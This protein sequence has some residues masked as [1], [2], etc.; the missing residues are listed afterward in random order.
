[1]AW[2]VLVESSWPKVLSSLKAF[3]LP[4]NSLQ[5]AGSS[6]YHR[7]RHRE[8]TAEANYLRRGGTN[9]KPKQCAPAAS[10]R[11][12]ANAV[13]G[14]EVRSSDFSHRV[15]E[16]LGNIPTVKPADQSHVGTDPNDIGSLAAS[17]GFGA[18]GEMGENSER[19]AA[20]GGD[21][22]NE[23]GSREAHHVSSGPQE[24]CG[25]PKGAVGEVESGAEEGGVADRHT[26]G[27]KPQT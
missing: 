12:Q 10:R 22:N 3:H 6:E 27:G 19:I 9:G 21:N 17:N 23:F 18:T 14:G 24:D 7:A 5:M 13:T 1:V 16:R 2:L 20:D 8:T 11:A 25:V 15:A 26:E 4:E